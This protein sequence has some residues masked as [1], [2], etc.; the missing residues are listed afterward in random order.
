MPSKKSSKT[1]LELPRA[2]GRT[3]QLKQ[4][5]LDAATLLFME[6]GY[7]ATSM[8]EIAARAHASKET[9]Y[10]HFPTKEVLFR[11]VVVRRAEMMSEALETALPTQEAPQTAL[12]L[13][14]ELVL[15]RMTT[16][17]SIAFHRVLG[18]AHKHLPDVLELYRNSG[19]HRVR[20]AVAQYLQQQVREGNLRS[21]NPQVAARQFF[22]L[23]AAE[24]VLR[25]NLS[26]GERPGKAAIRQ[27]VKES[28][29]CFLYGYAR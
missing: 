28:V 13:F 25:A 23:V 11:A 19:P 3:G 17:D 16:K 4:R 18:M 15:Q 7:E 20:D 29:D 26:G 12:T 1:I 8:T 10:R 14:G 5:L 2:E 27:R 6:N 24:M 9:F 21:L 22:D